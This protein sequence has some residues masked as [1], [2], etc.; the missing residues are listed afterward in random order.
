MLTVIHL[1]SPLLVSIE[2]QRIAWPPGPRQQGGDL[3]VLCVGRGMVYEGPA[4]VSATG[5][6]AKHHL[7]RQHPGRAA[8]A[9]A[10]SLSSALLEEH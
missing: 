1:R 9:M 5:L 6:Q 4:A 10:H 3:S 2:W 7:R 8:L